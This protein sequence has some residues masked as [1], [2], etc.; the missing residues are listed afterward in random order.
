MGRTMSLFIFTFMGLSPVVASAAGV[1]LK[2]VGL[3]SLFV[4]AGFTLSAVALLC[5]TR[6]SLR[7]IT[8]QAAPVKA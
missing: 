7:G 5:L 2:Y 4:G 8:T 3:G 6:P 1:L